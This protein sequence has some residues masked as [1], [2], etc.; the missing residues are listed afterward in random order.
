MNSP[1]KAPSPRL[2]GLD[3][4]RGLAAFSVML[5]HYTG[6]KAGHVGAGAPV[7]LEALQYGVHLFFA[8]SGFVIFL[9]LEH[10]RTWPDFVISRV[11]RLYPTFWFC[12]VLTWIIV[13]L[14]G[15]PGRETGLRDLA[16]N[17]TMMPTIVNLTFLRGAE[18]VAPVDGVYWSLQ[19]ELIFY[20]LA[21]GCWMLLGLRRLAWVAS[22]WCLLAA[23]NALVPHPLS[24]LLGFV[25]VLEWAPFFCVGI[26][27]FL[28]QVG[29]WSRSGA[30]LAVAILA[31]LATAGSLSLIVGA[32]V[33]GIFALGLGFLG[34]AR[35]LRPVIWL[36]LISYPLYLTHQNLGYALMRE[37]RGC[38]LGGYASVSLASLLAILLA[39]LIHRSVELPVTKQVRSWLVSLR[40]RQQ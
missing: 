6:E 12:M 24:R 11:S 19:V 30:C 35:W 18:P 37:L 29:G 8:I 5:Y 21:L 7:R 28:V 15:L 20:S 32:C 31:A 40:P 23:A 26:L 27:A 4:L 14:V 25:L 34:R 3:M 22:A 33:A 39:A 1:E 38:G 2:A 36:G 13:A 10:C 16:W 17:V 9:T